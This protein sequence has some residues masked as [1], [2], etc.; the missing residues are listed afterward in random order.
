MSGQLGGWLAVDRECPGAAAEPPA[1]GHLKIIRPDQAEGG[2]P[3]QR[4]PWK[5]KLRAK[6]A[7]ASLACK[8][9]LS[10]MALA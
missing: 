4:A 5:L 9:L 6:F 2:L 10:L 3:A 8:D 1:W 7:S